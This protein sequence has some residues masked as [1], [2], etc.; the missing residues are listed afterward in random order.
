M[1][2]VQQFDLVCREESCAVEGIRGGPE[3]GVV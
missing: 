3:A 1:P 2:A